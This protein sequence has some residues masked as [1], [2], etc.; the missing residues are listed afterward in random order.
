M[1]GYFVPSLCIGILLTATSFADTLVPAN[2]LNELTSTTYAVGDV[3]IEALGMLKLN[4]PYGS[5]LS[6]S[7]LNNGIIGDYSQNDTTLS[8]VITGTGCFYKGGTGTTVLTGTNSS[9]GWTWVA[10][11][12]LQTSASNAFSPKAWVYLSEGATLDLNNFQQSVGAVSGSGTLHLGSRALPSEAGLVKTAGGTLTLGANS[13]LAGASTSGYVVNIGGSTISSG[14]ILATYAGDNSFSAV[15][16]AG[17]NSYGS[18]A[19]SGATLTLSHTYSGGTS[20]TLTLNSTAVL[21]Y[22]SDVT[23]SGNIVGTGSLVKTGTATLTLTGSNNYSG[24]TTVNSGILNLGG[25]TLANNTLTIN[26]AGLILSGTNYGGNIY[27]IAGTS[28]T[29][30]NLT[31]NS[32][33]IAGQNWV[34]APHQVAT[35]TIS[36][37]TLTVADTN[38]VLG[39]TTLSG[40]T[41]TLAVSNTSSIVN[42][43]VQ[44]V[45]IPNQGMV[46]STNGVLITGNDNTDKTFA[47][48]ITGNGTVIKTGS[49]VWNL[50]GN[51]TFSGLTTVA[52]GVLLVNGTVA[53][54]VFVW[55]G[56]LGGSG[57]IGGSVLNQS[58]VSPGNS[59]GTLTIAGDYT[60]SSN[61][62][63]VIQ[64]A[65]QT[66]FDRLVVSGSANLDG[67]VLVQ[68]LNGYK[69]KRSDVFPFFTAAGGITGQFSQ[70][71]FPLYTLLGVTLVQDSQNFFIVPT[72]YP[73]ES[74][75]NLTPNQRSVAV[76]LDK[77][78]FNR[79]LSGLVDKLDSLYW[80]SVP[81]ALDQIAPTD[82]LS[83]FDASIASASVQDD[84][85]ERRMEEVRNGAVGVSCD[86]LHLANCHGAQSA[87]CNSKQAIDKDGKA[88]A[89]APLSDRWG[90]FINGSGEF[91]DIDS[92]AIAQGTDFT[93]G[94]ITAGADYRLG[95]H[96]AAGVTTGYANTSA[97]GQGDGKVKINSGKLGLYGTLFDC[98]FFLN[99]AVGGGLNNYDTEREVLGGFARGDTEGTD[100]NT[101]LGGGY[102]Y[103]RGA[104]NVGPIASMRYSWVGI[105]GFT[106]HGSLAP[107]RYDDQSESSLKSAVGL[108]TS[109]AFQV[110]KMTL[111]PQV[112]AQW[113]HEYL[114][115]TR[116]I[117]ASFLPGGAFNVQ[118]PDMGRD[119]VLLDAGLTL[120]L[121]ARVGIY[122][123]Y[124][125]ELW[126]KNYSANSI[127]GG[128]QIQ[129]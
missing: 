22:S 70:I 105:D 18:A 120:Q 77:V 76:A 118:G 95:N 2:T 21:N 39:S 28:G 6:N 55:G 121:N 7:I 11:G 37:S 85:L 30:T 90:F 60:Q 101:L 53:S 8:G 43:Q 97:D 114:D 69:P 9:T 128:V 75:P 4:L 19:L 92:S 26:G 23:L 24:T 32:I 51:N 31:G 100:F 54:D 125:G 82:L 73:V 109:Y 41:F 84:N 94:G 66:V 74:L 48:S 64:I 110:C 117:G 116:S 56:V 83:M 89:P 50:T 102:T 98:G 126:R 96:A 57:Y 40:S 61:G 47:G 13:V 80:T 15:S 38:G 127:N 20:G 106:E 99:G 25:G 36:S 65:S 63:L 88:L 122:A 16:V 79:H 119:G 115:A 29:L 67:A 93:T 123:F 59:P 111:T 108:Q 78:L 91:V 72:Q 68:Y 27:N 12:T 44:D 1:K 113:Q 49:G 124:T 3:S 87:G 17:T 45:V 129:F 62:L 35:W 52:D 107:L 81:G 86:G 71:L 34:L 14:C 103:R 5:V 33:T 58:T 112:R 42:Q 10:A 104:W 46:S